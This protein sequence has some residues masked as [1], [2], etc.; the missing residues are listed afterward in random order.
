MGLFLERP[1]TSA[2]PQRQEEGAPPR[3]EML[4]DVTALE[5]EAADAEI[6]AAASAT[7]FTALHLDTRISGGGARQVY[8]RVKGPM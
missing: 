5:E 1:S 8:L 6:T 3:W 7:G 2:A 4:S